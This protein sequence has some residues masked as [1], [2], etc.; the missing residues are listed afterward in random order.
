[1]ADDLSD[2]PTQKPARRQRVEVPKGFEPGV[3]YDSGEPVEV[4]AK[5]KRVSKTEAA[6]RNEIKRVTG[7]D[8]PKDRKVTLTQTR[9]WGNAD[10][11]QI[12]CRFTITDREDSS[13][14]L[15]L[16]EIIKVA[17][18]VKA[19]P[20][21]KAKATNKSL[22]IAWSDLQVGKVDERGGTADLIERVLDKL[23]RLEAYARRSD[24]DSAYLI[25]VGDM[26][27]GFENTASQSFTND[28][29]LPEQLRVCRR[30][31]TEAA[32][33]LAKIFPRVI[34][35]GV[36][37]NHGAWRKGKDY[38]G[39][40]GDDF[41]IEVLTSVADAFALNPSLNHVAFVVPESHEET[42]ALDLNGTI[43]GI[44]HGHRAAKPDGVPAWWGRQTHGGQPLASA[45]ILLTGHFHS[46]RVQTSGWSAHHDRAKYWIQAPSLDGGSSWYRH[47]AGEDSEPGLL[48]FIV[49]QD[50]WDSLKIF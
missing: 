40:A 13:K 20:R 49:D 42:L 22:V 36:P 44:A 12:Y 25:D 8:I 24:C 6:W 23:S 46:L 16:E 48:T 17:K 32:L 15:N 33:R 29:S 18:S 47:R 50:G 5:V 7:H 35:A 21:G 45:D 34:C 2:T 3:R 31:F 9:Y 30:L 28:L 4:T 11:P 41:G 37:S 38:L 39:K 43:L 27:E 14:R 19:N 26:L 1:M 10:S